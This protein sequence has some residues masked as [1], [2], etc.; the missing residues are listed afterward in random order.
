MNIDGRIERFALSRA[1]LQEL[2]SRLREEGRGRTESIAFLGGS[3]SGLGAEITH[4]FVP[5]GRGVT[6]HPL[7]ARVSDRT[8]A[9]IA[10][11]VDPPNLVLLGQVHTHKYEAFHSETDDANTLD[12]PGYL[13]IVV[14]EFATNGFE[15]L[16]SWA[17]YECTG[18]RSFRQIQGA[19]LARRFVI[20]G[21]GAPEVY[22]VG[23]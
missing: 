16:D 7:Y 5:R 1:L 11:L 6:L 17:V 18:S 22:Y 19:E 10:G 20:T 15:G 14:P 13:S 3:I 2:V 21:G 9:E 4:L 23:E 12:T 8:I